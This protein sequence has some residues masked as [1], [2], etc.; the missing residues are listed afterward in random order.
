MAHAYIDTYRLVTT[1]KEHG[2]TEE[3]AKGVKKV[4][5]DIDLDHFAT[6][7]DIREIRNEIREVELRLTIK[8]GA[9]LAIAVGVLATLMKLL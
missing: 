3:Q 7:A 6:K 9:M 2:F 1:L 8:M 4:I 5:E